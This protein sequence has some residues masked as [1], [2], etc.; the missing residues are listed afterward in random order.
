MRQRVCPVS[1]QVLGSRGPVVKLY[2]ADYPLYLSG[3]DC[4]AAVK[5]SPEKYLPHPLRRFLAGERRRQ[6]TIAR[7]TWFTE[8]PPNARPAHLRHQRPA[9]GRRRSEGQLPLGDR[10]K[11]LGCSSTMLPANKANSSFWA[12]CS[13]SGR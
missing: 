8:E 13:S 7:L 2:I 1:G 10:E 6:S 11:E 9:H 12:T 5:Q 3:E 4:I